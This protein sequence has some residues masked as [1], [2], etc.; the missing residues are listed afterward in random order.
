[1]IFKSKLKAIVEN[2][3][4][5]GIE[6]LELTNTNLELTFQKIDVGQFHCISD[7]LFTLGRTQS[8]VNINDGTSDVYNGIFLTKNI[9]ENTILIYCENLQTTDC[10]DLDFRDLDFNIEIF[11]EIEYTPFELSKLSHAQS[12]LYGSGSEKLIALA[13]KIGTPRPRP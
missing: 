13:E 6:C 9:D 11:E 4:I 3:E 10:I 1:M 12:I 8:Y 7:G 5:V 2:T